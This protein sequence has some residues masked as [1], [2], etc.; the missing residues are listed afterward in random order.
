MKKRASSTAN[1]P[2]Q[3]T[4]NVNNVYLSLISKRERQ[5]DVT[6]RKPIS[7]VEEGD[8]AHDIML[9]QDK[10]NGAVRQYIACMLS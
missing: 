2:E 3:V 9:E 6:K 8:R 5:S 1:I 4:F 10:A 7:A